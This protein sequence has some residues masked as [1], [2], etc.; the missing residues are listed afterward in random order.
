[1]RP[2]DNWP[3][4]PAMGVCGNQKGSHIM[5]IGT[6]RPEEAQAYDSHAGYHS[7]HMDETQEPHGSFEVFYMDRW[8]DG[9]N[10]EETWPALMPGWYWWACLP[11]CLP[12]GDP[13]GPFAYS[14]QAH[15]D[16]DGWSPDYDD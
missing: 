4:R 9:G 8:P 3:K 7:F 2:I 11:G 13:A 6:V 12:D 16:A 5:M 15:Q 10:R 1:M 14:Q